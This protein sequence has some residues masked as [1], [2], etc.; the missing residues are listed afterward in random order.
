MPIRFKKL[1]F[2]NQPDFVYFA[3]FVLLMTLE[4][5]E[6]MLLKSAIK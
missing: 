5:P 3:V 6:I 4:H 1:L 2:F